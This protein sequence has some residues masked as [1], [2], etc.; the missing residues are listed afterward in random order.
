MALDPLEAVAVEKIFATDSDFARR[1]RELAKDARVIERKFT[2]VG[3]Y[4]TIRFKSELPP[5][6]ELIDWCW[7]FSHPAIPDGGQVIV[8]WDD[9]TT[10]T[11]E[12]FTYTSPWP[13]D[14]DVAG[15]APA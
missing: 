4:S 5:R 7:S 14:L 8:W 15:F 3:I 9:A 6:T 13:E 2:G 11:L 1:M 12:G 10:I